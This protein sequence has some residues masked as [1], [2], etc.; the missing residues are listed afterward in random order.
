MKKIFLCSLILLS[1][2]SCKKE[3]RVEKGI[4]PED[5]INVLAWVSTSSF[6]DRNGTASRELNSPA[7]N[8]IVFGSLSSYERLVDTLTIAQRN[9]FIGLRK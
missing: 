9:M 4:P 3:S 8:R 6:A 1:L 2:F 5:E 7:Y